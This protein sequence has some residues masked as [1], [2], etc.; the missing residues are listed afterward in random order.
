MWGTEAAGAGAVKYKGPG[1]PVYKTGDARPGRKTRP[2]SRS[3]S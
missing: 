2:V 3:L 1:E